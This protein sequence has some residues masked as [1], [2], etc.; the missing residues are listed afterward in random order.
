MIIAL[1]T[2]PLSQLLW[3]Q[4]TKLIQ[5]SLNEEQFGYKCPYLS[6]SADY[7]Q[8]ELL[9]LSKPLGLLFD[10]PLLY[11]KPFL[12]NHTE[13]IHIVL[14]SLSMHLFETEKKQK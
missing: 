13:I 4:G 6:S 11:V 8:L 7:L 10:C 12:P 5:I 3:S 1:K 9:A 2:P 14:V